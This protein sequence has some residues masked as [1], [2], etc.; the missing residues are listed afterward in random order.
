LRRLLKEESINQ[1][2]YTDLADALLGEKKLE[3]VSFEAFKAPPLTCAK[4][5]ILLRISNATNINALAPNQ[6]VEFGPSMTVIFGD[7]ASGKSGYARILGNA[8]F[9]RGDKEV[10]PN[11]FDPKMSATPQ[12]VDITLQMDGGEYPIRH[13]FKTHVAALGGFYVFDSTC[14]TNQLTK[15]NNLSFSPYGLSMLTD[16]VAHTDEI[17]RIAQ[18]KIAEARKPHEFSP[19]FRGESAISTATRPFSRSWRASSSLRPRGE[20]GSGSSMAKLW[21]RIWSRSV[22]VNR[23]SR[24]S[25]SITTFPRIGSVERV[26][27]A[28][29][30]ARSTSRTVRT[31]TAKS[32]GLTGALGVSGG[33]SA[34]FATGSVSGGLAILDGMVDDRLEFDQGLM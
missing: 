12:S 20:E 17:R 15:A 7:N 1:V 11:V 22:A 18:G 8:C 21:E 24:P 30:N 26:T 4:A 32:K 23:V 16:L 2:E 33:S 13:D 10:L 34:S 14:V 9:T 3:P 5:P 19:L 29:F 28:G 27:R 31:G 6:T 25:R